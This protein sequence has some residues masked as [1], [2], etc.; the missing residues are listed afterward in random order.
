MKIS[1]LSKLIERFAGFFLLTGGIKYGIGHP[2]HGLFAS[3]LILK[4]LKTRE[5]K[6]LARFR[7]HYDAII[8]K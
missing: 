2:V 1:T 3:Y 8:K 4:N 7:R 6:C 5:I